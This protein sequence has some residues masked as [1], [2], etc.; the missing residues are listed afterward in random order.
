[1]TVRAGISSNYADGFK[2]WMWSAASL[3]RDDIGPLANVAFSINGPSPVLAEAFGGQKDSPEHN[4]K[5]GGVRADGV[6]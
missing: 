5:M 2:W 4:V 3:Q 1:M 6:G